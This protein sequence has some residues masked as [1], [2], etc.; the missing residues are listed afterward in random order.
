[1]SSGFHMYHRWIRDRRMSTFWWSLG[2]VAIVVMTAA[3][4]PSMSA[5][6]SEM[7]AGGDDDVMAVLMGLSDA[8]DPSSA[9][10]FL[11]VALYANVIPFTMLALGVAVG[12]AA[13]AGDE[14]TGV[15]EY[16]LA[17]PI[18]RTALAMSRF[19]GALTI[20]F[21]VAAVTAIALIICIPIFGLG[22]SVTTALP[23]GSTTTQPG[24]TAGDIL[25]G[26]F[27]AFAV[28]V[29][30]FGIAFLI[31]GVTGR[32]GFTT[33][34]SAAIV[35]GGYVLY[36]LANTTGNLEWLTW[37][38]PWRWYIADTMLISGLDWPVILPFITALV[39]LLIGWQVFLR[40]DLQNP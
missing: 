36:T 5:S 37:L 3:F 4:F 12:T 7:F 2:L 26:T 10:G 15:L 25:A 20:L 35:G 24:A 31:G 22:D 21:I 9:L 14:D 13:I 38:S 27:A 30:G 28:G 8:V 23:D 29:S 40:R 33:A 32:K 16:M 18:T 1:M 11:W 6:N 34:I 19:A 39:G 17:R